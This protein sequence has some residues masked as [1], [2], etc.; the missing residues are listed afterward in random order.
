M[1]APL[2]VLRL[3]PPPP[4]D[5]SAPDDA[6]AA[7]PPRCQ[8]STRKA[9]PSRSSRPATMRSCRP[10]RYAL[11]A[12]ESASVVTMGDYFFAAT[13]RWPMSPRNCMPSKRMDSTAW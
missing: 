4:N 3:S 13:A 2:F 9:L 11:T 8:R 1:A 6:D 7:S 5:E 12:V 10:V